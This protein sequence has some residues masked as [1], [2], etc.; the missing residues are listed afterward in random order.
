M[1]CAVPVTIPTAV[2]TN[3]PLPILTAAPWTGGGN[4]ALYKLDGVAPLVAHPLTAYSTT[5]G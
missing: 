1:Q 4:T 2:G 3:K 5:Y